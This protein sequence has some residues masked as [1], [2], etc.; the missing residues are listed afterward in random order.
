[1]GAFL[2]EG[3]WGKTRLAKENKRL[4][5][6]GSLSLRGPSWRSYLLYYLTQL[7]GM[8]RTQV[9]ENSIHTIHTDQDIPDCRVKIP[10]PWEFGTK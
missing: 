5:L 7:W 3:G 6:V 4:G 2:Q 10:Y 9:T 8:K 1:M